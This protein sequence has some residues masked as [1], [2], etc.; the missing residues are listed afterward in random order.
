MHLFNHETRFYV[1]EPGNY[2]RVPVFHQRVTTYPGTVVYDPESLI[3]LTVNRSNN[4]N[5]KPLMVY[6]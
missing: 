2:Y 6:Y 1:N 4:F 3:T 5:K